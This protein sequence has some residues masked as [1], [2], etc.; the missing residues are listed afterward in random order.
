MSGSIKRF[1]ALLCALL[2][3]APKCVAGE[4]DWTVVT[5]TRNGM[6]GVASDSSQSQAMS[7]AIR[8]CRATAGPSAGCGAQLTAAQDG[9]I[10]ANLCGDHQVIATGS[11]LVDAE[12]KALNCEI[13]LQLFYVPDLPP[14]KRI[15]TVDSTG[16]IVPSISIIPPTTAAAR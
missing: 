15:L 11:S 7:E 2:T 10:I 13:S 1:S 16:A 5:L 6:W 9:W 12:Q 8:L 4:H 14:C 3:I